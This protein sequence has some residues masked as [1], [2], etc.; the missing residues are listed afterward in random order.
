[1]DL[2]EQNA[3]FREQFKKE[4]AEADEDSEEES[5]NLNEE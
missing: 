1:M 2:E 5:Y 3:K 4:V